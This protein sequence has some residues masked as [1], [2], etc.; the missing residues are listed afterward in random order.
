MLCKPREPARPSLETRNV[1]YRKNLYSWEQL[2]RAGA[3]LTLA[4]IGLW[5]WPGSGAGYAAAA[6]GIGVALTGV[7]GFCPMCAMAG[8]RLKGRNAVE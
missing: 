1:I 2:L 8:R 4:A 7:L 5:A 6:T 3:G